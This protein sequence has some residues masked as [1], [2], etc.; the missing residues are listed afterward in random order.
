MLSAAVSIH[1]RT[2][3]KRQGWEDG[4]WGG[5]RGASGGF[6]APMQKP[7]GQFTS[8]TQCWEA[9]AGRAS[10]ITSQLPKVSKRVTGRPHLKK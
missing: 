9:E 7:V 3:T 4:L 10:G 8:L 6:P 5:E 2:S 1:R